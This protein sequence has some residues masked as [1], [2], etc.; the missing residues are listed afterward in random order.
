VV[1]SLEGSG[2]FPTRSLILPSFR[3]MGTSASS[4]QGLKS[5]E[6]DESGGHHLQE[7]QVLDQG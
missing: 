1:C 2:L 7:K 4:V 3:L 5:G 6:L